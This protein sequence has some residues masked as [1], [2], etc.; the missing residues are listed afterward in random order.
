MAKPAQ[1]K[2]PF[3]LHLNLLYPQGVPLKL[4]LRFLKWLIS[5]GRFI[6]VF[7]EII[8]L[9]CFA[10]RFKLDADLADLKEKINNQVPYLESLSIDEALIKQT[11]L[12]ILNIQKVYSFSPFW[13]KTLTEIS[14]QIPSQV[15]LTNINLEKAPPPSSGVSFKLAAQT[16]SNNDLAV[17]LNAL[18]K[19]PN[20]KDI[21]LSSISFEQDQ[22][23]FTINGG[24]K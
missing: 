6:V 22:I 1:K 19:S 20:L 21:S 13:V 16:P 9:A 15:R 17:F 14:N 4:P 8:V 3:R 5:Y 2:R 7:V 11:Q 12:R 10:Y 24:T 23:H 18:K